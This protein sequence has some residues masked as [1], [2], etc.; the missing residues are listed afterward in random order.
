MTNNENFRS[1]SQHF[2]R[3]SQKVKTVNTERDMY[4]AES[5]RT[6]SE[7]KTSNPIIS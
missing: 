5:F 1:L 2:T 7:K 4:Q 6:A 3:I